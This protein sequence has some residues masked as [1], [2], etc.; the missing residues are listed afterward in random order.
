MQIKVPRITA[1]GTTTFGGRKIIIM[2]TETVVNPKPTS[3]KVTPAKNITKSPAIIIA[4]EFVIMT[5]KFNIGLYAFPRKSGA[6][7]A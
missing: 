6:N 3:P 4:K 2:G 5:L 7:L 1:I